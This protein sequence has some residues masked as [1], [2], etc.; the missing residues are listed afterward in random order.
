MND[1]KLPE[2][3]GSGALTLDYPNH[4]DRRL[5]RT[6]SGI[7]L[8][9]VPR[10]TYSRTPRSSRGCVTVSNFIFDALRHYAQ[11]GKTP[12]VLADYIEWQTA[13]QLAQQRAIF[14]A[15]LEQWR[16]EQAKQTVTAISLQDI[17]IYRYPGEQNLVQM[18]FRQISGSA[19]T[20]KETNRTLYWQLQTDNNW[21]VVHQN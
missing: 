11:P 6:G 3:Y 13:E 2:L 12:I 10:D 8:H 15:L 14:D 16:A 7:W 4:W 18:N 21:K 1:D 17:D 19:E 5:K 9:G 20:A